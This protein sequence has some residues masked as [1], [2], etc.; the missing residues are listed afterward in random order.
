VATVHESK[1][2]LAR[3]ADVNHDED[4]LFDKVKFSQLSAE[5]DHLQRW[6]GSAELSARQHPRI[7]RRARNQYRTLIFLTWFTSVTT[8][9]MFILF[10]IWSIVD[11]PVAGAGQRLGKVAA[12][13]PLPHRARHQRRNGGAGEGAQVDDSRFKDIRTTSTQCKN[14]PS[15]SCGTN[16]WPASFL[17]AGVATRST[18][19]LARSPWAQNRSRPTPRDA[20]RKSNSLDAEECTVVGKYLRMIQSR[21]SVAKASP[22]SCL[23]SP[24]GRS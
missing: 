7:H 3:I 12:Q 23:T 9:V 14:A 16:N 19:P 17:A 1:R 11:S 22:K 2:P 15:K 5:V 21:R 13:F 6:R 18:I 20:R 24:H 10:V 8:A 4:W